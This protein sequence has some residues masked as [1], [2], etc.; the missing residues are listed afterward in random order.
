MMGRGGANTLVSG[1]AD[2]AL[3]AV[4]ERALWARYGL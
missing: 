3:A 4:D 2:E 1:L